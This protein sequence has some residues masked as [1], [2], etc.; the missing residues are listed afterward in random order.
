MPSPLM[1][2]QSS[3]LLQKLRGASASGSRTTVFPVATSR[4]VMLRSGRLPVSRVSPSQRK[5]SREGSAAVSTVRSTLPCSS[6]TSASEC[7]RQLAALTME[8]DRLR[9]E[10]I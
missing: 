7:S 6:D 5:C 4:T 9:T 3:A 2:S 10:E 8:V 1:N